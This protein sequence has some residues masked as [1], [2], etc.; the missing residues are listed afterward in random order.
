M[1]TTVEM[2]IWHHPK[3]GGP[4]PKC[5]IDTE[6][7]SFALCFDGV[8]LC[9]DCTERTDPTAAA[10]VS[11]LEAISTAFMEADPDKRAGVGMTLL[12]GQRA[13]FEFWTTAGEQPET[14]A[15]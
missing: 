12:E 4:C 14:A 5:G 7:T 8:A 10:V 1:S 2:N 9:P 3:T 6:W 15:S 11:A 13:A